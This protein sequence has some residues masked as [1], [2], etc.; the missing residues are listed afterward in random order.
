MGYSSRARKEL[1]MTERLI[2]HTFILNQYLWSTYCLP[3]TILGILSLH[4]LTPEKTC[5]NAIRM[6]ATGMSSAECFLVWFLEHIQLSPLHT[7]EFCSK[8]AF[9]NPVCS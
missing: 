7:N 8:S 2:T 6:Q 3:G 9:V 1:D 4:S 5:Q